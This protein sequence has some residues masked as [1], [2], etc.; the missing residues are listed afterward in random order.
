MKVVVLDDYEDSLRRTADWSGIQARAEVVFH[1]ERLYGEAVYD[2]VKDAEVIVLVRDRTPF[3]AA[4]LARLPKLKLFLFTGVRNAQ[5][6]AQVL[7][8][9]GIPIGITEAGSS[10]ESTSELAWTLILVAAKRLEAYLSLVRQGRWRDG[11]AL[12][13]TLA[14]ERLGIIGLGSIGQRIGAIGKTIGMEVVCWSPNMT[15]ERATAGGAVAV[16]LEEL[17][18]TSKVVSLSLVPSEK[19]RKLLNAERLATMRPDAILVNTARSAL[20]DMAALP[21]AL[22]AGRPGIAA[23][24]VYDEEPLPA[25]HAL[26]KLD[27]VVLSPHLGFVNEP[28]FKKFGEGVVENLTA[29]LDGKPLA[30]V[31]KP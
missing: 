8:D 21:A 31:F 22:A 18:S 5:L 19:T 15:P 29:W 28:V 25:G 12:P 30:R 16:S 10:K 2:A 24:D 9:R 6:D 11:K 4:L 17:L 20:I 26:A 13:T 7:I 3:K 23:L 14:G 1:T 27:N